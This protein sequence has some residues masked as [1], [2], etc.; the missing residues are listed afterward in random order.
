MEATEGKGYVS[1][2]RLSSGGDRAKRDVNEVQNS[3]EKGRSWIHLYRKERSRGNSRQSKN[4][5]TSRPSMSDSENDSRKASVIDCGD[6]E[7]SAFQGPEP[8]IIKQ[9]L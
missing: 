6:G 7:A 4:V 2:S 9:Q 8:A 1:K 3:G 5:A